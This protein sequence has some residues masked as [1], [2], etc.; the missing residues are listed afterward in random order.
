MKTIV[1][2]L[3]ILVS[4]SALV[5]CKKF[6]EE[7]PRSLINTND[8]YK[9]DGDAI[10]AINGVYAAMR[11]D[12]APNIDPIWFAEVTTD[13]ATAGGTPVGERLELENLVYSSQ[14]TFISRIWNTAF[15]AI[16][17]ANTV[18]KYVDSAN[19]TNVPLVR[20]IH[21][22]ARFLRA[23]YYTRLV[24]L[25]GDVPLLTEPST[26][27]TLYP[28]R[29]ARAE[30]FNKIIEDL[31]Y[32]E[33]NLAISYSYTDAQ[34]GGR[35]TAPAAKALL[36]YV[37]MVMAGYP[38]NDNTRWQMGAE[39]LNEIITNKALY[40]VDLNPVYRDIFDVTKEA[41]NKENIFQYRGYSGN[42]SLFA[43]TR[44][45]NWYYSFTTVVPTKDAIDSIYES[46]DGRR[47]VCMGK[48]SGSAVVP[49][50]STTGTPIIT[51]YIEN[52]ASSADNGN[53]F[54]VFRYSDVLLMYAECLV[55]MGGTANMDAALAILN[56]IRTA[57]G[58]TTL[59]ALTYTTQDQI[60]QHVRRE[61]RRELLYEGKRWYD[62]IRWGIYIPTMKAHMARQYSKPVSDY[63][64]ITETRQLL[65][66]PYIDFVN[67]P[68]LRPQNPGY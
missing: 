3:L 65:P 59:P 66:L 4:V 34:N 56:Q 44:F 48:K 20:R 47:L 58:G 23:F 39:K 63:D 24:Q 36:G 64:Y 8:F 5:S 26:P 54:H 62:L 52:I 40:G 12:V 6:L 29:T 68:N 21:A 46:A 57:H 25:F 2:I 33:A 10:S 35:A 13:D 60:R 7:D 11:P 19:L 22:E 16:N 37:Y 9:T 67:N 15:N 1:N 53:D 42:P 14:H 45:Q 31:K 51:K 55:E 50:T 61:R 30:V 43:Y 38:T 27:S 17:R 18:I 28:A 41:T 49:I 32:A